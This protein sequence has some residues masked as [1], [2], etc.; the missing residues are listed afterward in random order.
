MADE[1][2]IDKSQHTQFQKRGQWGI[3]GRI[4]KRGEYVR[5]EWGPEGQGSAIVEEGIS[6]KREL[7]YT[8]GM[9]RWLSG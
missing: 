2:Q 8:G 1:H 4:K 5:R 9:G 7:I 3:V 6:E